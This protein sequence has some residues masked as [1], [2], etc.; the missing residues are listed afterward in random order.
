MYPLDRIQLI[1]I[2]NVRIEEH[3]IVQQESVLVSVALLEQ[4]AK[5]INAQMIALGTEYA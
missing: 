2:K 4:R 5:E 1:N 3:V